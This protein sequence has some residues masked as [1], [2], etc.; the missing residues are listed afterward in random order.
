MI[1]TAFRL[2]RTG[3]LET[4]GSSMPSGSQTQSDL[5]LTLRL[6]RRTHSTRAPCRQRRQSVDLV[7]L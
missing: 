7:V 3:G 5:A 2:Q 4:T 1:R 6:E